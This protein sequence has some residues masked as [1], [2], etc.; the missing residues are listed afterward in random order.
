MT[1]GELA[2]LL[3][4]E[5]REELTQYPEPPRPRQTTT[6]GDAGSAVGEC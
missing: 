5:H 3:A 2:A 4:T 1:A 6:S